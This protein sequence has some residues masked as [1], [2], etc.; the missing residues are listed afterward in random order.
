[1]QYRD[2]VLLRKTSN[3]K[4][5]GEVRQPYTKWPSRG[6]ITF[7]NMSASHDTSSLALKNISFSI[8]SGMKVGICGRTGSGKSSLLL[9]ILR[10]VEVESGTIW[11]DGLDLQTLSRE[12]IR[13]RIITVP[14]DS[15]L[16]MSD[17]IRQNLDI[18]DSGILD[19]EIIF[20][21]KKVK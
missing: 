12:S 5:P 9:S 1:M 8:K 2:C 19:D 4:Q 18:A 14:Q 20:A 7:E 21:L 13:S 10:L 3:Q 11:V 17:T 16:V 15:M 6:S